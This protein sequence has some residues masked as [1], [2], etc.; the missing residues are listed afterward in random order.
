MATIDF[1]VRD[2]CWQD[3][4]RTAINSRGC[5]YS[6]SFDIGDDFAVLAISSATRVRSIRDWLHERECSYE[7]SGCFVG[8]RL[9][10]A[11]IKI[12]DTDDL[13]LLKVAFY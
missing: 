6:H 2:I 7:L 4:M 8:N 10:A 3:L 11:A 13:F 12:D 9:K 5:D 1:E